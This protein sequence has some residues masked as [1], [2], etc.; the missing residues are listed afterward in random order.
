MSL[1]GKKKP[2]SRKKLQNNYKLQEHIRAYKLYRVRRAATRQ[3][4]IHNQPP[5]TAVANENPV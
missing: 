5:S 3:A 1:L 2:A 4:T